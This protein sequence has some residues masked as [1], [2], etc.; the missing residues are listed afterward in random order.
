MHCGRR[1]LTKRLASYICSHLFSNQGNKNKIIQTSKTTLFQ[2]TC[3]PNKKFSHEKQIPKK[4]NEYH[5]SLVVQAAQFRLSLFM[6]QEGN[7]EYTESGY[8]SLPLLFALGVWAKWI[9]KIEC[10]TR[11]RSTRSLV[12]HNLFRLPYPHTNTENLFPIRAGWNAVCLR[13]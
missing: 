9:S 4:G 2:Q 5:F 7:M 1:H 12:N 6:W 3:R 8:T 11:V 13:Q 10:E